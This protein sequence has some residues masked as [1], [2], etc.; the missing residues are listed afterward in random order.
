MSEFKIRLAQTR[1][2]LLDLTRR[3]KLINYKRPTRGKQLT[4]IDESPEFLYQYLI[5]SEKKLIFKSIPLPP[6]SKVYL[7]LKSTIHHL[8]NHDYYLLWKKENESQ[9]RFFKKYHFKTNHN[10][11][12]SI[13]CSF[14]HPKLLKN[15][16]KKSAKNQQKLLFIS[17]EVNALK[18]KLETVKEREEVLVTDVAEGLGFNLLKEIPEIDFIDS[19]IKNKHSDLYIQTLHFPLELEKIL[20]KINLNSKNILQESG[21][22]MLYL[23]LGVLEWKEKNNNQFLTSPLISIPVHLERQSFN[24]KNHTYDYTLQYNGD[25]ISINESL[26]EKLKSDFNITLPK[27]SENMSFN[28]Y[29][30]EVEKSCLR[31]HDWKIKQEISLDFLQFGKILMYK[32]LNPYYWKK[33]SLANNQILNDLF[34]ANNK[35]EVS[36]APK[37]YNI[38]YHK[39]AKEVP[40]V[41]DADSSQHSAIVDVMQGKN[42]VIEGPPGTGKSQI[43][44][45]L[46]ASLIANNKS[47]LF[48][49]EKLVALEVVYQR[50]EKIGLGTFCLE[51]H[52]HKSEKKKVL[53]SLKKRIES[54]YTQVK[55]LT[56]HKKTLNSY[57]RR[58]Q[59]Y[60][61]QLH[62]SCGNSNK[63]CFEVFWLRE[64]YQAE[65]RY[66]N[67][68]INNAHTLLPA[69][70]EECV[71]TLEKYKLFHENYDFKNY[72]WKGFVVNNFKVTQIDKIIILLH[73]LYESYQ[74]LNNSFQQLN[75]KVENEPQEIKKLIKFKKDFD[76]VKREPYFS[77]NQIKEYRTIHHTLHA[78]INKYKEFTLIADFENI[79]TK[80]IINSLKPS[81]GILKQLSKLES[82]LQNDI[83]EYHDFILK[84]EEN[85]KKFKEIENRTVIHFH[86]FS[87]NQKSIDSLLNIALVINKRRGSLF[88]IFFADYR[89][90]LKEFEYILKDPLP[91]NHSSWILFLRD[92]NL[93][94]LNRDNQFKLR[95]NLKVRIDVFLKNIKK[96]YKLIDSTLILYDVVIQSDIDPS[97]KENFLDN[98]ELTHQLEIFTSKQNILDNS[99][100]NL[101]DY[102]S[103]EKNF[104]PNNGLTF[105]DYLSKLDCVEMHK[106]SLSLWNN[107]QLQSKKL[108]DL[109]LE[110]IIDYVESNRLPLNKIVDNFYFNYYNSV[111]HQK[112]ESDSLF[113]AFSRT[114]HEYTLKKFRELDK[115]LLELN[116]QHVAYQASRRKMPPSKGAGSVKTFTNLKLLKHEIG[117]KTRHVPIR[118]LINR[119]G[120]ALQGLK[121]CFMMSPLSV[122]QYLPPDDIE[123]DILLIDEASQLRPEEALGVIAR[124]KQIVIVGDPKQL[125]PTSFFQSTKVKDQEDNTIIDEAES[126]LDSCID[127]Y[128]P[129]RRL[130]WHYR[131]QHESLIDFSNRHFY[132]GDLMVF[133]SPS[134]IKN[135]A[136]GVKHTYIKEGY[137]QGGES[138]R[139]NQEEAKVVVEH[140][141]AQ[142]D[143]YPNKSLGVGTFNSSQKELIQQLI[144][145]KEKSNRNLALYIDKWNKKSEPFFIKNLESLQGDERDVI[146]ISTTYGKD[147]K[148]K[149]VMQRFGPINQESGWRRLNVLITRS[150]QKMHIFTS[151]KSTDINVSDTSSRGIKAFRNFLKFLEQGSIS[152]QENLS[153]DKNSN[154]SE[155][156][157]KILHKEGIKTASNIGVSGY[158]L[159]LVVLSQNGEDAILAIESDGENY[160]NSKSTSDRDRLKHEVLTRLGWSIY[161]IWSIDW[162]KNRDN[163]IQQLLQTIKLLQKKPIKQFDVK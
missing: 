117:K 138:Y 24:K 29:L 38:D 5:F 58:L 100:Q 59:D 136:Y 125:A 10:F 48:V 102:A 69:T 82:D 123:F 19:D 140:I 25:L 126:I 36:Y 60:L 156:I 134:S 97:L 75:I 8:E 20:H 130:K 149:K 124:A 70:V 98:I 4:I 159:D 87:L 71:A 83:K 3:N 133:P 153:L 74:S 144:D 80:E 63:S 31:E 141:E 155:S 64:K 89:E 162:Y 79:T 15:H 41:L 104:F 22:N 128:N 122:S 67:I 44:A 61:D 14:Q 114:N 9:K 16:L 158:F 145:E 110:A 92:L 84:S 40:L 109:G 27:L 57:K 105:N 18:I 135:D 66:L 131:S 42:V 43:I 96:M 147:I 81:L 108:N 132:D 139:H 65:E 99:Y 2:K 112:F 152:H 53:E 163:E 39:V 30:Q 54:D 150:K 17:Q 143:K 28:N 32:D 7:K 93:Y 151:L 35:N 37:E 121:P 127:L 129:V 12:S 13:L 91:K 94:A 107:F 88:R 148:Y 86:T 154:F 33:N 103:I 26:S 137:Y 45:N 111:L 76:S 85:Y 72:F 101:Y 120:G 160:Y 77:A 62:Q 157:A 90:A 51:L 21:S 34:L 115:E 106:Q 95:Y 142:I 78:Y 55:K 68:N 47:V 146:Y 119:A 116:K 161:R 56:L 73:Q 46:I 23:I 113:N 118:D 1:K 11:N 6:K 50:L 52:S 49:S